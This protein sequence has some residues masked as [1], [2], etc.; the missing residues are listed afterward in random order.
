MSAAPPL[1]SIAMPV[2]NA[3]RTLGPALRSILAQSHENWE[4]LVIDDGSTDGTAAL[5]AALGDARVRL[6]IGGGN[7]GLAAR[8]NQAI[9]MA[10]GPLIARMDADDLAF[11][12]RIEAQVKFMAEH[13]DCDLVGCGMLFF[14]EA[15]EVLGRFPVRRTHAEICARP[16]SGFHLP[17]PTWLGKKEWFARFRYLAGYRKTQ[18]QDLLLRTFD[19][20]RFACIDQVLLGYRQD[21]RTLGKLLAGRAYFARSI[22]RESWRRH[23]FGAGISGLAEQALKAAVD[24]LTV[25]AGLHRLVRGERRGA[26]SAAEEARWRAVWAHCRAAHGTNSTSRS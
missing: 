13:P 9:D 10:N 21:R 17:H 14:D 23:D 3:A 16:W 25:P 12:G 8:L 24:L 4:L 6:T 5:V 7:L 19:Q 18:D 26:L 2:M 1:V 15:G 20:S 22:M 11:P